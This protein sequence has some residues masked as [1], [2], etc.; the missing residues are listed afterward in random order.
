MFADYYVRTEN[1]SREGSFRFLNTE[2]KGRAGKKKGASIKG[3]YVWRRKVNRSKESTSWG[4][5]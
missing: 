1:D 4:R 5:T 2:K 3:E